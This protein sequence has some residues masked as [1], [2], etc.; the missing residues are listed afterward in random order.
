MSRVIPI[1]AALAAAMLV[2]VPSA[3]AQ[4]PASQDSAAPPWQTVRRDPGS[5]SATR[6]APADT[7][8]IR[9][10][11]RG[12]FL[13][14]G[15]GRLGESRA[16]DSGVKAFAQRMISEHNSMN[17]QWATLA[18]NNDMTLGVQDLAPAGDQSAER[19]AELDGAAFD[20]AYM[21]EMIR[22]H[23]Q[24][25][26]AFQRMRS[27]VDSPEVRQLADSGVSSI[28]GHLA[29]ARQV[30]S[31]VGVSTTTGPT[32]GGDKPDDRNDRGALRAEDRAFVQEV[33][34][35]HL[36]HIRLAG[37]AQRE[38]G[39]DETRRLAERIEEDFTEWQKRW[40]EVA[41]RYEVKAPSHLGT[42]HGQ[43]LERLERAS[44]RNLDRTYADIVAEHLA[45]VVPYFQKEGQAVRSA[46]VRRLVDDELPVIR[47][48][49][50]RARRLQGQAKERG[51][52]SDRK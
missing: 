36:M 24:D 44:K 42:L 9:Q 15:L 48:H 21:A 4:V 3:P 12:N 11:I 46:A 51:E 23:E 30:G 16:A 18:R 49:L 32:G 35:D 38:A 8:F 39:S 47:E 27:S 29:L 22:R 45:S 28:R 37:R 26:A 52:A 31:R 5:D 7:A 50:A 14:A 6:A 20:R 40:E 13:E 25:L 41:E 2:A 34:Q 1:T 33:L 10:V 19:L 43:K 17:E